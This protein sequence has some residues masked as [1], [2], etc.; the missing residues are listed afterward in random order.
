MTTQDLP[1]LGQ[2]FRARATPDEQ[3]AAVSYAHHFIEYEGMSVAAAADAAAEITGVKGDTVQ[4]WALKAGAGLQEHG[5]SQQLS[6]MRARPVSTADLQFSHRALYEF[7]RRAEAQLLAELRRVRSVTDEQLKTAGALGIQLKRL[8]EM[9]TQLIALGANSSE[10]PI[11]DGESR[12]TPMGGAELLRQAAEHAS[13][14]LGETIEVFRGD[15]VFRYE[16]IE[17]RLVPADAIEV[18][19]AAGG[20][21]VTLITCS[22][23]DN[24]KDRF[25]VIGKLI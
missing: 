3:Y 4:T 12:N 23:D 21:T 7:Q 6:A 18:M 14:L 22:L 5:E 8:I 10:L 20:A 11:F 19:Q 1:E 15:Q 2:Q 9:K 13:G 17:L 16:V 25:V 24:Y